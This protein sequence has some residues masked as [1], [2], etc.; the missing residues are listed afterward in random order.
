MPR[1][2]ARLAA[3]LLPLVLLAV[4]GS[5]L[6]A[7]ESA[8]SRELAQGR[9]ALARRDYP[10]AVEHLRSAVGSLDPAQESTALG[11]AW[12]QLGITYLN[13]LDDPEQALSAFLSS[14]TTSPEPSTAWLWASVTAEILGRTQEAVTYRVRAIAP[15]PMSPP[16]ATTPA[17]E[18]PASEAK[19][20]ETRPAEPK[21]A[22]ARPAEAIPAE[23]KPEEAA[24]GEAPD[25]VQHFFGTE[26][27]EPK[28]EAPAREEKPKEQSQAKEKEKVDAVQYFFGEKDEPQED[29]PAPEA[30]PPF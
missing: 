14:V 30:K 3:L 7:E 21:P 29:A 27:P 12:L 16:L 28:K 24:P 5:P 17:R 25:A 8:G 4:A 9:E 22:E 19:P 18:A 20:E 10:A 1:R 6:L 15:P 26:A 2:P 11:D 23:P 13:G